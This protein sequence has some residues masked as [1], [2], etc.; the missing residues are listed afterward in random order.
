MLTSR[1]AELEKRDRFNAKGK[2]G[3]SFI[4]RCVLI[5][6]TTKNAASTVIALPNYIN[7]GNFLGA[8]LVKRYEPPDATSGSLDYWSIIADFSTLDHTYDF[9]YN[10]EDNTII[11]DEQDTYTKVR[12]FKLTVFYKG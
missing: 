6:G 2:D 1:V 8:F 5:K 10:Q 12:E 4:P 3:G 7:I 11:L 9:V